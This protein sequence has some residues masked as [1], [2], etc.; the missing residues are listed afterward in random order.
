MYRIGIVLFSVLS[1]F[2]AVSLF[3]EYKRRPFFIDVFTVAQLGNPEQ[4]LNL[5]YCLSD[6]VDEDKPL[7]RQAEA[8]QRYL[9]VYGTRISEQTSELIELY[10]NA[11][12]SYENR[13]LSHQLIRTYIDAM[14]IAALADGNST[15]DLLFSQRIQRG[16]M[17]L[18]K[19]FPNDDSAHWAVALYMTLANAPE[20]GIVAELMKCLQLNEKNVECR[21][22]YDHRNKNP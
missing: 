7:A 16:I 6:C 19:R 2:L 12:T 18:P 21:K 9:S 4:E 8:I 14:P 11:L 13:N 17:S 1:I 5:K 20:E 10:S 3:F 22:A 15:E